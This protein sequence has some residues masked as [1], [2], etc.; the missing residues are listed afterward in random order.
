MVDALCKE[1]EMRAKKEVDTNFETLYFGG[2]TPSVLTATQLGRIIS[3]GENY[4]LL[5]PHAEV[6]LEANPEDITRENLNLWKSVGINRLSIGL[7]SSQNERL[8][9][10]NR[11]SSAE[12]GAEKVKM[13]QDSGFGNISLDL[14]YNLPGSTPDEL[15]GDLRFISDLQPQHISAYGLTIEPRTVFGH[16]AKKGKLEGL[17]EES[18]AQQ[19]IQVSQYLTALGFEHYEISNFGKPGFGAM[20]NSNY[21]KQKNYWGIGPSA[22]SLLGMVRL[23]NPSNNALYCKALLA[24]NRLPAKEELLSRTEMANEMVLTRLRTQWGLPV[25]ELHQKTGYQIQMERK[26][27]IRKFESAN[28]L[29]IESGTL[30]LTEQGRL[31]ADQISMELMAD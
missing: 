11:I 12:T 20:H 27:E 14:M 22:H 1:L 24:E 28:L 10:M 19:F 7:Q 30:F 29:R 6:T 23:I 15:D 21:W 9:W 31:L 25:E 3:H 2:G 13:A 18:A 8:R 17:P 4:T 16:L 5:A 26:N